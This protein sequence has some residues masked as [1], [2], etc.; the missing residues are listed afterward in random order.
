[1][2][3]KPE[4]NRRLDD[5][6]SLRNAGRFDDAYDVLQSLALDPDAALLG[7]TTSIALPRRLHSAFLKLAKAQKDA[8]RRVGLQ[9]HLVP[10]PDVLNKYAQFTM[11]E[12]VKMTE[13]NRQ[14]VPRKI[15][16]IWIGSKPAPAGTNAWREHA[17][18]ND[19]AYQLWTE[20]NLQTLGLA[21]SPA[22]RSMLDK[23]DLPGA[24]DVARYSILKS[25]GGVYLDCDWYPVRN[26][27]SFHDLLPMNGLVTMAEDVPRNTGKGSL[28]L[29]NSFIA[30]PP[31]HPV[32]TRLS[33]ALTEVIAELPKA[34]AWWSTGPLLFT[35]MC[36]GG[37][38]TLADADMVAGALSQDI[39]LSQVTKWCEQTRLNDSG[40]LLAWRSW[41]R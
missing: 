16:Q 40:L 22:Y 1:M 12:R 34:P 27:I 38:V 3:A 30:S 37:S 19:Y 17:T 13:A 36:R 35:L 31:G 2:S 21:Q 6:A 7:H 18:V 33:N 11:A 28:L 23:G 10:P 14:P 5:A 25:Y 39:P 32:F 9:Y 24:V 15:H 41:E 4:L 8:I 29:A 20:E 26:D